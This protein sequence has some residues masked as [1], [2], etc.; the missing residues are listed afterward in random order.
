MRALFIGSYPNPLEPYRSAFFQTLIHQFAE[1]GVDCTVIS[2]V[3]VTKYRQKIKNIPSLWTAKKFLIM[4]DS[5]VHL[6]LSFPLTITKF[7]N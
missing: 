3:S 7:M 6:K 4:N 1:M 5:R 2:A